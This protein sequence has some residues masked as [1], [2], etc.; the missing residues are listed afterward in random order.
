MSE[1]VEHVES[2]EVHNSGGH[3]VVTQIHFSSCILNESRSIFSE[4]EFRLIVDAVEKGRSVSQILLVKI[5]ARRHS[6]VRMRTTTP[7]KN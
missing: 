1:R 5:P 2:V 6:H 3:G 4:P 7:K